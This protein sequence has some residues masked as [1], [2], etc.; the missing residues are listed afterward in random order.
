MTDTDESTRQIQRIAYGDETKERHDYKI[1]YHPRQSYRCPDC[2]V[3][4]GELHEDGCDVEQCPVCKLQL[5]R[6]DHQ[7]E[8]ILNE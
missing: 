2:G 6:C 8:W 7:Y 5:I 3:E 4:Q 1:L